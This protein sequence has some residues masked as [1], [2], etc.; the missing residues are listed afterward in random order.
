M[1]VERMECIEDAEAECECRAERLAF[2]GLMIPRFET[3]LAADIVE[4]SWWT[5]G[6]TG[7]LFASS[8]PTQE[9]H[10]TQPSTVAM[11]PQPTTA[12][13]ETYFWDMLTK[14]TIKIMTEQTCCTMTVESA[15]RGQKS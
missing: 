6:G 12:P 11:L 1:T 5:I 9:S 2:E 7:G 10:R 13:G 4:G 15:T 8:C 3:E 14:H